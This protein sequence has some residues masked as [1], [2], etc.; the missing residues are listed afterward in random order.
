[1]ATHDD[2][3]DA[4]PPDARLA[5]EVLRDVYAAARSSRV[6]D[7]VQRWDRFVM[8]V[9]SAAWASDLPAAVTQLAGKL[10]TP[11]L[12]GEAVTRALTAPVETRLEVL[13]LWRDEATALVAIVRAWNDAR[14]QENQRRRDA[15]NPLTQETLT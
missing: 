2:I 5:A 3:L 15:D 8:R 1:M 6:L 11:S 14:K 10:E 9:Q 4:L 7:G 12:H 13:R